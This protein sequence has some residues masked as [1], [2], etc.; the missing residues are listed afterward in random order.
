MGLQLVVQQVKWFS[1]FIGS[2]FIVEEQKDPV[3]SLKS[4]LLGLIG[5]NRFNSKFVNERKAIRPGGLGFKWPA[6][7]KVECSMKK[8]VA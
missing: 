8:S 4:C 6:V 2:V 3:K 5:F 1:F 7:E